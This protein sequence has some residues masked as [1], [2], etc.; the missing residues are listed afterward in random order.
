MKAEKNDIPIRIK[1]S[2]IQL[3]ELQKHIKK[4]TDVVQTNTKT[5][6]RGK[7]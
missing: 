4:H 5:K 2:G 6:S 3:A 7:I 1:I